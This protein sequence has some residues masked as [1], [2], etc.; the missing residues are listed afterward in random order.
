MAE[1]HSS[2]TGNREIL[3]SG[4]PQRRQSDGKRVANTLSAI[5][6]ADETRR[7]T[8]EFSFAT[9]WVPT[10]IG[11]PL[12]LKTN[13]LSRQ[14]FKGTDILQYNGQASCTQRTEVTP[15]LYELLRVQ[16]ALVH[17]QR[18]SGIC[19]ES[20]PHNALDVAT[21]L[22]ECIFRQR[23]ED[24]SGTHPDRHS[25][26]NETAL[27]ARLVHFKTRSEGQ[28]S[29]TIIKLSIRSEGMHLTK[30][31]PGFSRNGTLG[32]RTCN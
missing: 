6:L 5:P 19:D 31:A 16:C 12:L 28:S 13:L 25:R 29:T 27:T 8:S 22:A 26:N 4:V 9:T 15:Q 2:H 1:R 32:R 7:E 18:W 11:S 10:R 3:T 21:A 30:D 17:P 23:F 20:S 24:V 14:C